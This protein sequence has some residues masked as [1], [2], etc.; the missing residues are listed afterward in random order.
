M[1][2]AGRLGGDPP[3]SHIG[4]RGVPG[5]RMG[6]I[7][8]GDRGEAGQLRSRGSKEAPPGCGF[9]GE[10]VSEREGRPGKDALGAWTW[11]PG[12]RCWTLGGPWAHLVELVGGLT[13]P[14][15]RR[16]CPELGLTWSKYGSLVPSIQRL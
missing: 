2:G 5:A 13:F 9:V 8:G 6:V 10:W 14:G 11:A 16:S 15:Q 1:D 7:Q 4:P 3:G 12:R